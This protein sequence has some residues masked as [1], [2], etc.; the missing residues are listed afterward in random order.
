MLVDILCLQPVFFVVPVIG[1]NCHGLWSGQA[2]ELTISEMV[3]KISSTG[4]DSRVDTEEGLVLSSD[5]GM[6]VNLLWNFSI[7]WV[8]CHDSWQERGIARF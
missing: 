7:K 4:R 3:F 5:V 2:E 1:R 8:G 6:L